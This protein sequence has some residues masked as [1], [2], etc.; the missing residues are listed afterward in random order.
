MTRWFLAFAPLVLLQFG[1]GACT[2]PA[3]ESGS[4]A[5]PAAARAALEEVV[6]EAPP[7][8]KEPEVREEATRPAT[9]A[10]AEAEPGRAS[11]EPTSRPSAASIPSAS[12]GRPHPAPGIESPEV[13]TA[14][15]GGRAEAPPAE[16]LRPEE[17]PE[18]VFPSLPPRAE[19]MPPRVPDMVIPP[20]PPRPG[21]VSS[22]PPAQWT[23]PAVAALPD[24]VG[25]REFVV[26]EGTVIEI[27]LAQNLSTETNHAGDVFDA[28]LERDIQADGEVLFP[29]GSLVEGRITEAHA[30]GRVK[31]RA[32]LSLA[33][34]R[35]PP[36]EGDS[37]ALSTNEI[38]LEADGTAGR[39]AKKVGAAAAVGTALGAIL[40]GRRGAAVGGAAG[41][42]AGAGEVL[43]TR[44]RHVELSRE[45]LFS[46]R[47]E[48]DLVVELDR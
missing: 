33:L 17:F 41:A 40:G 26:P 46:F 39:D 45:R 9:A 38:T 20:A 16:M 43:L 29:R 34:V 6:P 4:V 7:E 48:R 27:R 10:P 42:G 13:P 44:G 1:C 47:L 14:P 23:E 3:H 11:S 2:G 25:P 15:V 21:E 30:P 35:I 32:L 31:G 8:K 22:A 19:E 36:D 24:A 12:R 18:G 37:Y 28:I 5:E